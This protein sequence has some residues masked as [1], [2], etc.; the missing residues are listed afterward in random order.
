MC[1]VSPL[2]A[3][4]DDLFEENDTF[5]DAH[6]VE[7]KEYPNL[8]VFENDE[9]WYKV[10]ANAGN[11]L[12]I[13]LWFDHEIAGDLK[14]EFYNSN[15]EIIEAI[16]TKT[17]DEQC[18]HFVEISGNYYILIQQQ[19]I[20]GSGSYKMDVLLNQDDRFEENDDFNSAKEIEFKEYNLLY[21]YYNDTDWYKIQL[22]EGMKCKIDLLFAHDLAG[23]LQLEVYDFEKKIIEIIDTPHH[24][25]AYT[26]NAENTNYYY[27]RIIQQN[28]TGVTGF[29]VLKITDTSSEVFEIPS[30][31]PGYP[32]GFIC[33]IMIISLITISR[34][35]N[36]KD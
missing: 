3:N 5:E 13:F 11:Y 24:N 7:Y 23:D 2:S 17:D 1:L 28:R 31:I 19:S 34:K 35:Y 29:Y 21:V 15:H 9:D 32:I 26:I 27:L 10:W 6:E 36:L 20:N 18:V 4:S 25:E 8:Y 30:G 14:V 33:V 16:D 12:K 22:E